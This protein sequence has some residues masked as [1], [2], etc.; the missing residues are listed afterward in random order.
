M[1]FS[2]RATL[3]VLVSAVRKCRRSASDEPQVRT[4]PCSAP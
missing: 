2:A 4:D 3:H 1:N